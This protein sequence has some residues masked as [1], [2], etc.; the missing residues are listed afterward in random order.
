MNRVQGYTSSAAKAIALSGFDS[1]VWIFSAFLATFLRFEF[2]TEAVNWPATFVFAIL[3]ALIGVIIGF[4][5]HLYRRRYVVGSVD[6]LKALALLTLVVAATGTVASFVWIEQLSVPRSIGLISAALF[7]IL[8]GAV[9]LGIR[10]SRSSLRPQNPNQSRAIVYGAGE[11]AEALIPQLLSN[12]DSPYVPV[13]LLDDA[14]DKSNRWIRGIPMAGQ[15]ANLST[16]AQRYDASVLIVAIPSAGSDLLQSVYRE[17]KSCAL[18]VVVVPPLADY[19]AGNSSID[20]LKSLSVEDLLGRQLVSLSNGSIA[21]LIQ[22]KKILI[23]GAGGSIGSELAKQIASYRPSEILLVDRDETFLLEILS[24]LQQEFSEVECVT[25]LADIRD[26]ESVNSLFESE[27]PSVIFHAAALKHVSMLERFPGEAWKTNVEGTLNLLEA[28]KQIEGVTFVNISTD[29][30]ANPRSI[31][32]HSKLIAEGLTSYFNNEAEGTFASVRFGNVFRSRGSLIPILEAQIL[33][34]GPVT[35]TDKDATRYFMSVSEACQLV[36]AAASDAKG[37][38]VLVLD[39]GEPVRIQDIAERLIE[40]S[41]RDVAIEYIGLRP[42]EKLHEELFSQGQDF[43]PS[44]HPRIFR[45]ESA[46]IS[47]DSLEAIRW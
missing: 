32:G 30:A 35:V 45:L 4:I 22:G 18:D 41:G 19:L 29:K 8:A 16:V 40:L 31:L 44:S 15:F 34:G 42:G 36:L 1:M 46:A 24:E 14:P 38:D 17:S 25:Y 3:L 27:K 13:A 23:T 2:R 5:N 33:S 9:R 26:R 10:L 39:M 6:E 47:P 21:A 20:S 12:P 11:A 37:G 28:A 7:L 43:V